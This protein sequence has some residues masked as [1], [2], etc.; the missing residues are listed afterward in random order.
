MQTAPTRAGTL[1]EATA[2]SAGKSKHP[3]G[4]AKVA[5]RHSASC[6]LTE[7]G[8]IQSKVG[9]SLADVILTGASE[10]PVV[11]S[12]DKDCTVVS[13]LPSDQVCVLNS[14][15]LALEMFG[16]DQRLSKDDLICAQAELVSQNPAAKEGAL[17]PPRPPERTQLPNARGRQGIADTSSRSPH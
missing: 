11:N 6:D 5:N 13:G 15:N 14:V 16:M 3:D 17:G 8:Q 4:T 12:A 10:A 1:V 7:D 9:R 2:L